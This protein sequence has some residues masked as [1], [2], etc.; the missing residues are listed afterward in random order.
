MKQI[1]VISVLAFVF[2]FSMSQVVQGISLTDYKFPVSTS[3]EAYLNGNYKTM[4]NS[5]DSTEVGYNFGGSASYSLNYRSLPFSYDFDFVGS[6]T[7]DKST[8][9]DSETEEAYNLSASTNA[10]KYFSKDSNLFGYG[11][12]RAAYR[13]LASQDE[14]DDPRVDLEGGAGF[15][16]TI[17]ATVLK[18]AIRMNEDFKKYGVITGNIPDETLLELAG[19]IDR[20]GEYRSRFGNVEYRKYWYEDMEKAIRESGVL[21]EG[22]LGAMGIV[23]IQEV[24]DEPTAQRWHGWSVR[25]GVGARVSDYD[26]E[27]GDPYLTTR[28]DWYRPV[29]LNLQL[30]NRAS[31]QTVFEEDQTYNVQNTFRVDYEIS[32]RI[33]W[34]NIATVSYDIMTADGA[35]DV[36][37]LNLQ[38]TYIFYIENQL[39]FNPEFQYNYEDDGIGD[40]EWNWQFLGSISYRLR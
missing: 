37:Q 34:Y 22:G 23:R 39:T 4:G 31:M 38:S 16:R 14:A 8:A 10:D 20:E 21:S 11:L 24:L 18:Q 2:M 17:N 33:D 32:N 7:V 9:E 19:I 26:G 15:G 5:T 27:S 40:S 36:L 28:F 6:F 12:A 13:K 35:E 30:T 3:Q 1:L 29:T 25:A